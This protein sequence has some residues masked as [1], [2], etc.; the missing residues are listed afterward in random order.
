MSTF[1]GAWR[2][3]VGNVV[4]RLTDFAS[5]SRATATVVRRA[6]VALVFFVLVQAVF[7]LS[8]AAI[9]S[10][11]SLGGL[12]GIVGV[13]LVLTYRTSRVIN[14]AAAAVGAVPAI[15]AVL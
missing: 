6:L 7:H 2:P 11:L 4:D 10:G 8:P 13:A 5:S 3:G 14:F 15:T 12:Y 9:I 1:E